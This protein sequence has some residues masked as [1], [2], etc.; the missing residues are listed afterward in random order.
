MDN[1]DYLFFSSLELIDYFCNNLADKNIKTQVKRIF[2]MARVFMKKKEFVFEDIYSILV[3]VRDIDQRPIVNNV[4]RLYFKDGKYPIRVFI[5]MAELEG[6]ADIEM[7]FSA[8]RGKKEYIAYNTG[9]AEAP[10]SAAVIV[11]DSVHCSGVLPI[12]FS[13]GIQCRT[14]IR[15]G[16]QQCLQNLKEV[17]SAA[18]ADIGKVYTFVIYIND[19]E[20][21][22]VVEAAFNEYY[23]GDAE[24]LQEVVIVERL[25]DDHDIEISCSAYV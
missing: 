17:L 3:M 15:H 25:I 14:D 23:T 20:I 4:F 16:V 12:D 8:Y 13:T 22:P 10:Y 18:G 11:E 1:K 7:E 9:H 24:I 2:E 6:T 19:L 21:L 5:Q